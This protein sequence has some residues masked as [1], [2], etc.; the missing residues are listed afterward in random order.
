MSYHNLQNINC[1]L[2]CHSMACAKYPGIDSSNFIK[3]HSK[4]GHL[5]THV[6]I[7]DMQIIHNYDLQL[8]PASNFV[9]SSCLALI[10]STPLHYVHHVFGQFLE[11]DMDV[12]DITSDVTHHNLIPGKLHVII[13][14]PTY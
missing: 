5:S 14:T 2:K 1:G 12:D 10:K 3:I 4:N 11:G 6:T 8:V 9:C 13:Y 7:A